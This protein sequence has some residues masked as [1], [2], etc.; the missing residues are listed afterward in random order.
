MNKEFST[1]APGETLL[2]LAGAPEVAPTSLDPYGQLL[3]MLQPRAHNIAIY[4]RT[5]LQLWA[6]DSC[7]SSELHQLVQD[8]CDQCRNAVMPPSATVLSGETVCL[9]PIQEADQP[10]LGVVVI[11]CEPTSDTSRIAASLTRMLG[12]ALSVLRREL[13]SQ[14]SIENLQRDIRLRDKDLT[15]LLDETSSLDR[16]QHGADNFV[17]L[18]TACLGHLQCSLGALLVPEKNIAVYRAAADL[19]PQE[20]SGL[21]SRTHR[22]LFAL[23]QVQRRTISLNNRISTGP[24]ANLGHKIITCPVLSTAQQ[25]VGILVFF[26]P[27]NADD[28]SLREIHLVE[29]LSRRVTQILLNSYDSATGLLT[30]GAL[31]KRA[32]E[33]LRQDA[34]NDAPTGHFVI[35]ADIDRLHVINDIF[36]MHVGDAIIARIATVIREAIS[37]KIAAAKISGDRFA[38]F[39]QDMEIGAATHLAEK[40][41][42]SVRQLS[43]SVGSK[44]LEVS[45][46]FGLSQI[47]ASDHP[48][49]HALASAEAACK[50]AKDRGRGRVEVCADADFSIIRRVEDVGLIGSIRE[51]LEHDRFRMVAQPIV[52]LSDVHGSGPRAK[53]ELLLRMT[54]MDGEMITPDKFFMAAERY[55]LGTA[56]DR[57]VV[58]YVLNLISAA[59]PQ[60]ALVGASFAI[61]LSGQSVGDDEFLDF[62]IAK[63]RDANL[64][65]SLISFELTETAAV[66][67]IVR[68]ESMMRKLRDMGH[69]IALDDFGKGLSS[70]SYLQSM[71][72]SCV[73]I[74]GSLIRDVAS[75]ER[76]Q[77]MVK[78][79]V[80]LTKAMKLTTT[81]ECIE[82][83]AIK[84]VIEGLGV[85]DAQGYAIGRPEPL[86]SVLRELLERSV[87]AKTDSPPNMANIEMT[88]TRLN[89]AV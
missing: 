76:S 85:D 12:P 15:L 49:S 24:L 34:G 6:I 40:L 20:G 59:S 54:D 70:L 26:K 74:D 84:K 44:K 81:A 16:G 77:A 17:R 11:T 89:I 73:K 53:Y 33:V 66:S 8:Y 69:E 68:A 29:L 18:V 67:N 5:A 50:A 55:Q 83:E 7:E 22:H 37:P 3:R 14:Y 23:A 72:V 62:L 88:A 82:S 9:L 47:Q 65:A 38:L 64:P 45:A 19:A 56:I 80:E 42:C 10:L 2:S 48:L 60:L 58:N 35:Y 32:T 36:G 52:A 78:A 41:C 61:N 86:E 28:F 30:R 39:L 57:W 13:G 63:L 79:V 75:N 31:E 87:T 51:A 1:K 27:D 4:D 71:P 43:Y 25:V 46:S 21:L